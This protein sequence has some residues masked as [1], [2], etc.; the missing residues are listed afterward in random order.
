MSSFLPEFHFPR[1]RVSY[2]AYYFGIIIFKKAFMLKM[3][4]F[5]FK[6]NVIQPYATF[7]VMLKGSLRDFCREEK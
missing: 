5:N 7:S 2:V 1:A 4:S 6:Q 3:L